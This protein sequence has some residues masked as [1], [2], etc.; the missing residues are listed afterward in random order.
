[1]SAMEERIR[2]RRFPAEDSLDGEGL[3]PGQGEPHAAKA[4]DVDEGV[5]LTYDAE[6][7][8]T[9]GIA[10]TDAPVEPVDVTATTEQTL[11]ATQSPLVTPAVSVAAEDTLANPDTKLAV[12]TEE[13]FEE[14]YVDDEDTAEGTDVDAIIDRSDA[15]VQGS[16][17]VVENARE[18]SVGAEEASALD[19]AQLAVREAEKELEEAKRERE[20]LETVETADTAGDDTVS[21][22]DESEEDDG[23]DGF[24]SFADAAIEQVER[25][26]SSEW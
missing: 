18:A 11:D 13:T 1:M 21:Y 23:S 10:G 9:E 17:E 20:A 8:A 24:N 19:T 22:D 14:G 15:I 26:D 12:V 16:A 4:Q 3:T 2:V 25:G 5:D 7:V 6:E